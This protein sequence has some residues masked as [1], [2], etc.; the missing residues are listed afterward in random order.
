MNVP[1]P[2]SVEVMQYEIQRIITDSLKSP[3]G[4]PD[5]KLIDLAE[6]SA[7]YKRQVEHLGCTDVR[8][9]ADFLHDAIEVTVRFTP[10][11]SPITISFTVEE[12]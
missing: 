1:Q 2:T 5:Y 4:K 6:V 11:P 12:K 9:T 10:P 7:L 8:V 3:F